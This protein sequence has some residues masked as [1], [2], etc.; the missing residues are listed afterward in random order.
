[1]KKYEGDIHGGNIWKAS[2]TA[3]K[4]LTG[5]IDF[6][7]SINPL[8]PPKASIKAIEDGIRLIPPYPDP[9]AFELREA[10]SAFHAIPADNILPANGS[11]ELIY[12]IPRF[13]KPGRALI[14][15]PAFS[16]YR[17]ALALS[18][19]RAESFVLS[20]VD[21]F[22]LDLGRL[23]RKLAQGFSALYIANPANPTGVLYPEE[24]VLKVIDM[25]GRSGATVVLD[26]AFIDFSGGSVAKEAVKTENAIVLRSLTKFYSIAG[27]RLGYAI[28][29]RKITAGLSR[30]MP[31][32]SVNTLASMAGA[33]ALSDDAYR[34]RTAAWLSEEKEFLSRAIASIKGLEPYPSSA[35]YIMV[36][37]GSRVSAKEL[38]AAL[39]KKGLLIRD[40]GA[41]MGLGP[42]LFRVAVLSREAN[43]S[44]IEALREVF[45]AKALNRGRRASAAP[46][47]A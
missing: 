39:F 10:L 14:V 33:A 44:L 37:I 28:A 34:E 17:S 42:E 15:E 16:E 27:L 35:N 25:A 8:G 29:N 21:G 32:W 36:R 40:L 38:A 7:A 13:L 2:R 31:P 11:T 20:K 24:E 47:P 22:G 30:L 45:E 6:S 9:Y 3:S 46:E 26:E 23:G 4:S 18:D 1:L 19:I 41:F 43:R 12:L 5:I